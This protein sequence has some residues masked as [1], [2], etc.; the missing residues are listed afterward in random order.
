MP[1]CA[2]GSAGSAGG[3][4]PGLLPSTGR[5]RARLQQVSRQDGQEHTDAA[6]GATTEARA[7]AHVLLVRLLAAARQRDQVPQSRSRRAIR[8]L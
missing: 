7:V 4:A 5:A 1:R 6:Q 2:H 3:R 8:D